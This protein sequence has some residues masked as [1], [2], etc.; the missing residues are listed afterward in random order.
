MNDQAKPRPD[1]SGSGPVE[2]HPADYAT[3]FG[4]HPAL[5]EAERSLMSLPGVV[6]VGFTDD[7]PGQQAI[8]VGVTDAAVVARLPSHFGGM[9]VIVSVTGEIEAQPLR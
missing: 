3:A 7:G 4:Q 9:R 1:F 2:Y 6:S 8:A 5:A